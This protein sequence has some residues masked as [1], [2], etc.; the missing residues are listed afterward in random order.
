MSEFGFFMPQKSHT[1]EFIPV[2][3]QEQRHHTKQ[4]KDSSMMFERTPQPS[5]STVTKSRTIENPV[6]ETESSSFPLQEDQGE[7]EMEKVVEILSKPRVETDEDAEMEP[8]TNIQE[9]IPTEPKSEDNLNMNAPIETPEPKKSLNSPT[10]TS[11]ILKNP[12]SSQLGTPMP[13]FSSP[14]SQIQKKNTDMTNKNIYFLWDFKKIVADTVT[15]KNI[16]FSFLVWVGG[17]M[18]YIIISSLFFQDVGL[19]NK[20]YVLSLLAK[21]FTSG[22]LVLVLGFIFFLL[23]AHFLK[24]IFFVMYCGWRKRNIHLDTDAPLH[25]PSIKL[26]VFPIVDFACEIFDVTFSWYLESLTFR[27]FL[28]FLFCS[29]KKN[30][31]KFSL[32]VIKSGPQEQDI[33]L[34]LKRCFWLSSLPPFC[35]SWPQIYVST[36][37]CCLLSSC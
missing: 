14:S 18:S 24:F 3:V 6:F 10:I 16:G 23:F 34:F 29:S 11:T 17:I 2:S 9:N 25:I 36:H 12:E 21:R 28:T 35:M 1:D 20:I 13:R 19:H 5:T 8:K 27:F 26:L 33:M 7:D 30:E 32:F 31:S 37:F 4:L 22:T 15:Y